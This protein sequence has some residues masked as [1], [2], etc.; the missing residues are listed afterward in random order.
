M[1]EHVYA[2]EQEVISKGGQWKE[3]NNSDIVLSLVCT[4]PSS[5]TCTG[6]HRESVISVLPLFHRTYSIKK[7][8]KDRAREC[9]STVRLMSSQ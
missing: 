4:K 2:D 9:V 8:E 3:Q 1:N 6:N 7:K 5:F